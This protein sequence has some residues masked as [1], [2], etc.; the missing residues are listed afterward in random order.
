MTLLGRDPTQ[1]QKPQEF[2]PERFDPASPYYLT[3]SGER[4]HPMSFIP[5]LG[6]SR[7]CMGGNFAMVLTTL[8]G[9]LVMDNYDFELISSPGLQE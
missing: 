4:R 9:A 8:F 2:L 3:P 6:G 5:F 7:I 1:W